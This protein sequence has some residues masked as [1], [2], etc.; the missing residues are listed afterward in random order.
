MKN[1]VI[2]SLSAWHIVWDQEIFII[3]SF[4]FII[5]SFGKPDVK[6]KEQQIFKKQNKKNLNPNCHFGIIPSLPQERK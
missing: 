3:I 1:A 2:T 6:N 5:K 4:V